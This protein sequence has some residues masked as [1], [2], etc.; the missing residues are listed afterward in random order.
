[1]EKAK[2]EIVELIAMEL[3]NS[4]NGSVKEVRNR[5]RDAAIFNTSILVRTETLVLERIDFVSYL[6]TISTPCSTPRM[7]VLAGMME[8]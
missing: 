2:R 1:M 7:R 6:L 4:E 5:S 8:D 3:G